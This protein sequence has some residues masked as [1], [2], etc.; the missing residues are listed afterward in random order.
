M[1]KLS[2]YQGAEAIEL[3]ADL[4]EPF[5]TIFT[6][7]KVKS[8]FTKGLPAMDLATIVLKSNPKEA[9]KIL[10]RI[11]NTPVN[12]VNV[13]MRLMALINDMISDE[14]AQS[15]FGFAAQAKEADVSSGSATENTE[16]N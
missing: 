2:D 14:D 1:K 16:D 8:G 9:E 6:S 13:L 12:G 4:L 7:E 5:M 11:D 3:W 15:F 10:L